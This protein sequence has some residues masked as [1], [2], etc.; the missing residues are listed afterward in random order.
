VF[1]GVLSIVLRHSVPVDHLIYAGTL[2]VALVVGLLSGRQRL[3]WES[4]LVVEIEQLVVEE[5]QLAVH[6][7]DS[8]ADGEPAGREVHREVE[9]AAALDQ[10]VERIDLVAACGNAPARVA[11]LSSALL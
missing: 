1:I 6:N 3:T 11:A 9:V 10:S 2:I 8:R 7:L 5:L 4:G